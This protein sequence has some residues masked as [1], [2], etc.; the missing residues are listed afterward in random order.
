[1]ST[2]CLRKTY[3]AF[4]SKVF[5]LA[6]GKLIICQTSDDALSRGKAHVPM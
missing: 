2:K 4:G 1:M 5:G 3:E 6:H